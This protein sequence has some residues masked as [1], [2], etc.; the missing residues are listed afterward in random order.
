MAL[1]TNSAAYFTHTDIENVIEYIKDLNRTV[2]T[3]NDS[4]SPLP[5]PTSLEKIVDETLIKWPRGN[6]IDKEVYLGIL[7]QNAANPKFRYNP[8]SGLKPSAFLLK[9]IL[10]RVPQV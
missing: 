10:I 4:S 5:D 8:K 9:W 1:A 3:S 6:F 2:T 7:L